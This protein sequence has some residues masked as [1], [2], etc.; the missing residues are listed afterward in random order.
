V[1]LIEWRWGLLLIFLVP[2]VDPESPF[3]LTGG[4]ATVVGLLFVS[5]ASCALL[6]SGLKAPLRESLWAW[7][8]LGLFLHAY[9]VRSFLFAREAVGA[10]F[11]P[12][13]PELNWVGLSTIAEGLSYITPAFAVTC[14]CCWL[15]LAV[16]DGPRDDDTAWDGLGPAAFWLI[17]VVT[18]FAAAAGM[19]QAWLGIGIMGLESEPLP[20][21]LDSILVRSRTDVVPPLAF[22]AVWMAG[23]SARPLARASALA[24]LVVLAL[25]DSVVTTSRGSLVKLGL[26]LLFLW[27][28]TGRLTRRRLAY[29]GVVAL[30]AVLLLPFASELRMAR[31]RG[32]SGTWD[33]IADAASTAWNGDLLDSTLSG[34]RLVADRITGAEG[35]WFSMGAMP[36]GLDPDR[37]YDHVLVEPIAVYYTRRVVGV[38]WLADFRAPGLVGFAMLMG[39]VPGVWV[40]PAV[41]VLATRVLWGIFGHFKTAPV[42]RSLWAMAVFSLAMEGTFATG[43]VLMP[44]VGIGVAEAVYRVL[45]RKAGAEVGVASGRPEGGEPIAAS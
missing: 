16:P 40:V 7:L 26:P 39:G 30:V 2:I 10:G 28:L 12:T 37:L 5:L 38:T 1:K 13:N 35:V 31:V 25:I 36:D 23:R 17:A 21:R 41:F 27:I 14:V 9:Y 11:T 3:M 4:Y 43:G 22:L 19:L 42:A 29:L 33:A 6:L 8:L 15:A 20:Y 34:G 32:A 24:S 45:I 44:V 18:A